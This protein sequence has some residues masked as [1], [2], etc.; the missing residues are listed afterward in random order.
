MEALFAAFDGHVLRALVELDIPDTLH[1]PMAVKQLAERIE[2]DPSGLHRLLRYGAARGFVKIDRRGRVGPT[3]VTAALRTDAAAPWHGWVRFA[4][5]DWADTALRHLAPSLRADSSPAFELA[6]GVDFFEF[7]TSVNPEAGE[8]FDLAM[9]AGATLQ[10]IVLARGLDWDDIHSVCDVGGGHG[11][12]LEVIQRY[13]PALTA[14]LLDLPDVVARSSFDSEAGDRPR[15]TVGGS[16]FDALPAGHDRYLLLAIV[17]DWDDPRASTILSNVADAMG[18]DGEAV[19]VET[20]ASDRPR[21]DFAAA[22]DLLMLVLASGRERTDADYRRLFDNA[23]LTIADQRLLP[24]GA[25]AFTLR[26]SS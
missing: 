5:S 13:H 11:A 18:P 21:D 16:F 14:V 25:T 15:Q 9:T 6:H 8:T 20:I 1:R 17:H 7:T 2:C 3:G 24:T 19:V 12:T 26:R 23:G 22:S 10:G 4:T